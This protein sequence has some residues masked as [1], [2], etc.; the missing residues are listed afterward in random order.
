MNFRQNR[1]EARLRARSPGH[2]LMGS[3]NVDARHEVGHDEL[4]GN[5]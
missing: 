3:Q 1:A 5:T 4:K 2:P